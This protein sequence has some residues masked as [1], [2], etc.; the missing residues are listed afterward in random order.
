MNSP[1]RP[2]YPASGESLI[3]RRTLL[4]LLNT[5]ETPQR[6]SLF[7]T[8]YKAHGKRCKVNVDSGS[9]N[10]LVSL[11]MVENLKEKRNPHTTPYRVLWLS[12]GQQ[13]LLNDQA[14]V[15]FHIGGYVDKILYDIIPMDACHLL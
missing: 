8:T 15:D 14:W 13:I 3:M 2:I 6:K 12:K 5:K 4:K 10:N 1:S 9:T 7:R 11:E